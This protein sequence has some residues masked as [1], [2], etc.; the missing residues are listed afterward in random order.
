M[1][2]SST[3]ADAAELFLVPHEPLQF[4]DIA[5]IAQKLDCERVAEFV[6]VVVGDAS[7]SATGADL[8]HSH[9]RF[10][11]GTNITISAIELH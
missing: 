8:L 5:A 4:D 11:N 7:P 9:D 3:P 10:L 2:V 1:G 6:D